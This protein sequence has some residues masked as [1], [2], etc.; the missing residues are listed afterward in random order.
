LRTTAT[1]ACFLGWDQTPRKDGTFGVCDSA[2]ACAFG[3]SL[4]VLNALRRAVASVALFFF[5]S[6]P[7]S[8]SAD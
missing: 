1:L 5:V 7:L 6:P 8:R 3:A 2:A 4:L